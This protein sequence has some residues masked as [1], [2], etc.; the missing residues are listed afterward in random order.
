MKDL[1]LIVIC[2]LL[3]A[4]Q[5][6]ANDV[7]SDFTGNETTYDLQSGSSHGVT[8]TIVFK[9]RKDGQITSNIQLKGTNGT[10][11]H[12]VHLHLGNLSTPDADIALLLTPVDASTGRSTTLISQLADES[13]LTY[14]QL[15]NL[16]A[17]VKIHLGDVGADRD[18][19]LAAG[20]IGMSFTKANPSGRTGIA[21]CKSE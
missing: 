2:A 3:A 9:E 13:T 17:S 10:Q 18:V 20:D 11:Q 6:A 7:V 1:K 12:P 8:G 14:A 16:E 15:A 21:T 4:C 19:I 5:P